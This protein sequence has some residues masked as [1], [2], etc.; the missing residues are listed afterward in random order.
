MAAAPTE[1]AADAVLGHEGGAL[2][3]KLCALGW[4]EYP[5]LLERYYTPYV[6]SNSQSLH[7]H[8][9]GLCVLGIDPAHPQ[10][11]PPRK[12]TRVAY[13]THDSK[14]LLVSDVRGK[15]KAGAV[16]VLPRDMLCEVTLD[17]GSS[18][19]VYAM[20]RGS[21]IEINRRLIDRPELLGT[22]TGA[23]YIAV[24]L[25]KM[26]EKRSIGQACM[27]FDQETPLTEPS[28]NA[29]RKLEGK[30]VRT[31]SKKPARDRPPCWT[32]IKEG[33]CK[34]GERCRFAHVPAEGSGEA[35]A[36]VGAE[37]DVPAETAEA[38]VPTQTAA[39]GEAAAASDRRA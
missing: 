36:P 14:N 12:V 22:S 8:S 26:D 9:N 35:A 10:L 21:V 18:F 20:V 29:K 7:V 6:T 19:T 1:L 17:D 31:A 13:R 3:P 2:L 15:K 34:F 28:G 32:F 16:F 30:R 25:P 33:A 38:A 23:G 27:E 24:L 5:S 4:A 11:A 39:R 37:A